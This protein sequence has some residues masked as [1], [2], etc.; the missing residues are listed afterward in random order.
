MA[1]DSSQS[2]DD[3]EETPHQ[4]QRSVS[5]KPRSKSHSKLRRRKSKYREKEEDDDEI[6]TCSYFSFL[7]LPLKWRA[8]SS[9]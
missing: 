3:I 6:K 8:K 4:R 1:R 7:L 2:E 9:K 5:S